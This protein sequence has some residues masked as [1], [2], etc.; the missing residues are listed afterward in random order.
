M[1]GY[2]I[3]F[4][5]GVIIGGVSMIGYMLILIYQPWHKKKH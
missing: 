3:G 1:S 2:W 4:L 5:T